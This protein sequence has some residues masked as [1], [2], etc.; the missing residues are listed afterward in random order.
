[1]KKK[2]C[3]M[4]AVLLMCAS[5]LFAYI[6]WEFDGVQPPS[7]KA[8]IF[9]TIIAHEDIK[10]VKGYSESFNDSHNDYMKMILD[11]LPPAKEYRQM[12]MEAVDIFCR[13]GKLYRVEYTTVTDNYGNSFY[14]VYAFSYDTGKD[15]IYSQSSLNYEGGSEFLRMRQE[16]QQEHYSFNAMK[17]DFERQKSK[18]IDKL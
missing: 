6:Y 12:T 8:T 1:M 5:N 18:Y 9:H 17:E 14:V 7:K 13:N 15:N 4:A 16:Y 11:K 2:I 3:L 10:K